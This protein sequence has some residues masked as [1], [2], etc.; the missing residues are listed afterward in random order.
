MIRKLSSV[1]VLGHS[2][3]VIRCCP[4]ADSQLLLA[5]L[6]LHKRE[7]NAVTM[8]NKHLQNKVLLSFGINPCMKLEL[9]RVVYHS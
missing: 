9:G 4:M 2:G 3:F 5:L 6:F 7:F 1:Y 8:T